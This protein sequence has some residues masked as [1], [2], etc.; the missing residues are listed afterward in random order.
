MVFET[1]P[2][3]GD[4]GRACSSRICLADRLAEVEG[5]LFLSLERLL[6]LLSVLF[7]SAA[8]CAMANSSLACLAFSSAIFS[9]IVALRLFVDGVGEGVVVDE[10]GIKGCMGVGFSTCIILLGAGLCVSCW[11]GLGSC[12]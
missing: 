5:C 7:C 8:C 12:N 2:E 1:A 10:G 11:A 9:S 4:S 3:L 6:S